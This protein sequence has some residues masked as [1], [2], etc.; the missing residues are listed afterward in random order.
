MA[1]FFVAIEI[2]S[3]K[4]TGIAGQNLPDGSMKVLS[5][6]KEDGSD[7]IRKGIINNSIK[8]GQCLTSIINRLRQQL[9]HEITFVYVGVGGQS[10]HSVKNVITRDFSEPTEITKTMTDELSDQNRAMDYPDQEILDAVTQEYKVDNQLQTDP[11][12]LTATHLE[13]N[14]LNILWRKNFSSRLNACFEKAGIGVAD[15]YLSPIALA[16]SVLTDI[17]KR[18]GCVL[19]DLG[20][21]TTTVSVYNKGILRHMAVIPLGGNNITKDIASLT[22]EESQAERM[23]IKYASAYTENSEIDPT[24]N[25]SIDQ[26]RKVASPKFIE[27]VEARVQEIVDNVW[28]QVPDEFSEHPDRLLGGIILTGGG[29]KMKNID[30]PFRLVT[31]VDKIRIAKFVTQ[32]VKSSNPDINAKDGTMNTILGL[33]AKADLNCAGQ[34]ID[35]PDLFTGSTGKGLTTVTTGEIHNN[36]RANSEIKPG[37]IPTE[38]EK[39][40]AEDERRRQAAED[41][42]KKEEAEKIERE[43]EERRRNSFGFKL[44]QRFKKFGKDILA[45]EESDDDSAR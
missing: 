44:M 39:K 28:Y 7:C 20:A 2:G 21:D 5:V 1:E 11:V 29:S 26:D 17:E 12:G 32:A 27:I 33:L 45:E 43:K 38:A 16:D 4:I 40:K 23:K 41:A 36:P 6:V 34:P 42:K 24:L 8:A 10:I 31:H 19:V 18:G 37:V 14:F 13:A 30:K 25:Y 15:F 9:K 35:N 22:M 3:S